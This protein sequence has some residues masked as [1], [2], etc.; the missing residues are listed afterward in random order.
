ARVLRAGVHSTLHGVVFA[1][2][3]PGPAVHRRRDAMPGP[4]AIARSTLVRR[5][6]PS[7]EGGC[8]E[9]IHPSTRC[10]MDCF[11]EPVIGRRFAPTRWLAMTARLFDDL[12]SADPG[13]RDRVGTALVRLC[14]PYGFTD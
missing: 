5:S 3:C 2:F 13:C 7:G 10:A 11:A 4:A 6:P 9:A 14:P 8:D 12:I 1:I